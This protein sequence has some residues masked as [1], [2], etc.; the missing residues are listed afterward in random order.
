M[1]PLPLF[2]NIL[3]ILFIPPSF[4]A[5]SSTEEQVAWGQR[6]LPGS[7]SFTRAEYHPRGMSSNLHLAGIN[8]MH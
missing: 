2:L 5:S 3:S 6:E 4:L 7:D 8:S 1:D